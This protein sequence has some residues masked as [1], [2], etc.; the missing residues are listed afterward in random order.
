ML[1]LLEFF[2]PVPEFRGTHSC[3]LEYCASA[4]FV[5]CLHDVFVPHVDSDATFLETYRF[6]RCALMSPV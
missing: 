4:E 2:L 6:Q 3:E 5:T 1:A